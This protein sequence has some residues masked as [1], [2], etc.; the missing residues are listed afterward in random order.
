MATSIRCTFYRLEQL[1]GNPPT[2]ALNSA[3]VKV[4]LTA[5]IRTVDAVNTLGGADIGGF[6][7]LYSKVTLKQAGELQEMYALQTVLQLQTQINS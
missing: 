1:P 6:G 7:Y 2:F 5:D 4:I 3:P